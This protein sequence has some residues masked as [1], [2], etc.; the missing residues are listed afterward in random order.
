MIDRNLVAEPESRSGSR[1]TS[2]APNSHEF[3][4]PVFQFKLAA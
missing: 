3:G 4:Y 2:V 1:E